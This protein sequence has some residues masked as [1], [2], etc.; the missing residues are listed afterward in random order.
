M[1]LFKVCVCTCSNSDRYARNIMRKAGVSDWDTH[2]VVRGKNASLS[3]CR[4]LE[5]MGYEMSAIISHIGTAT[6][7]IC[8]IGGHGDNEVVFYADVG[9]GGM[10]NEARA[11]AL[12]ETFA[13]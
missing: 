12:C 8:F 4:Q 7:F 11:L 10:E 13:L 9:Y 2:E 6:K 5:G 1:K 3:A